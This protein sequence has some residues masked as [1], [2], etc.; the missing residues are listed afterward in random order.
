MRQHLL[1]W[2]VAAIALVG[3][4]ERTPLLAD[5]KKITDFT[6]MR[7]SADEIKRALTPDETDITITSDGDEQKINFSAS[8][9]F[10]YQSPT[11]RLYVVDSPV[12]YRCDLAANTLPGRQ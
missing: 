6:G 10:S 2:A 3:L 4:G 9:R 12:T 8:H 1:L 5:E 7:P 11:Q